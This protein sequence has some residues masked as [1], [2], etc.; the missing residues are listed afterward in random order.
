MSKVLFIGRK[1]LVRYTP[2]SGN[3]DVDKVIQYIEIAQ[4]VHVQQLTGTDLYNKLM[5]DIQAQTITGVYSTIWDMIKPILAHYSLLEYL[6]FAQYT[7]GNKGVFKHTSENADVAEHKDIAMMV[8]KSRD[9]AQFYAKRLV[10]YLNHNSELVP[11]YL[12]NT[13][14]DIR[15][16]R[17]NPFGGWQI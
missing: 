15:P 7:I 5:A 12:S 3:L 4:D 6:P 2:L 8:E 10:D 14:E 13:E 16:N 17:K 11:E 1:D 9:T